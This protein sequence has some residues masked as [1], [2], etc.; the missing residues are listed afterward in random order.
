MVVGWVCLGEFWGGKG[1]REGKGGREGGVRGRGWG[2]SDGEEG[3]EG[4]GGIWRGMG[5][6]FAGGVVWG[7]W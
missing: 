6:G 1:V 7:V 2:W 4:R 3:E 5:K